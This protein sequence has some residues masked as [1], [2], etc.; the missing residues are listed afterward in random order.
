MIY[1]QEHNLLLHHKLLGISGQEI[2]ELLDML[3]GDVTDLEDDDDDEDV[4]SLPLEVLEIC[5]QGDF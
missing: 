5:D 3:S 1:L 4:S 2:F